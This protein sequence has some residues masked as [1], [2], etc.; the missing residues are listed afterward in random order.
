MP[1]NKFKS[2]QGQLF[3]FSLELNNVQYR[4][5]CFRDGA[6]WVV[7]HGFKKPGAQKGKGK[8]PK[9]EIDRAN[10]IMGEYHD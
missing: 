10:R 5:P 3:A 8:W 4:F 7:T 9:S 1:R 2:E 6:R